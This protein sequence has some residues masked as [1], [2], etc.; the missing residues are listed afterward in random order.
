MFPESIQRNIHNFQ[1]V[2]EK[3]SVEGHILYALKANKSAVAADVSANAGIGLDASS[4]A[5]LRHGLAHG[6][7]G[8]RIGI[9]GPIK[10]ARLLSL[11]AL[12]G[13]LVTIDALSELISF[14]NLLNRLDASAQPR[15]L[16]RWRP[17]SQDTSR[18]GMPKAELDECLQLLASSPR[19]K[20][21]GFSFHLGGYSIEERA[22]GIVY[23]AA[24]LERAR[25]AGFSC[26]KLNIGGGMT[27]S[28]LEAGTWRE[29]LTKNA[30]ELFHSGRTFADF[31]PYHTDFPGHQ[32]LARLLDWPLSHGGTVA[33]MLRYKRLCLLLEPG[34][35]LLDQAGITLFR[36]R[37]MKRSNHGHGIVTV[38]GSSFSL[39][40]QW[41][42]S[43]F[44]PDP[45]L[46]KAPGNTQREPVLACVSGSTCLEQDMVS[47]RKIA[48]EATPEPGDLLVYANT[49]GYQMD[50]NESAFHHNPIPEKIA[51]FQTPRGVVWVRDNEF[52]S[53]D[54]AD[55]LHPGG[56]HV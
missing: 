33:E 36:V 51:V 47:W 10:D 19:L 28:Y 13:C 1:T 38:E 52:S 40:E 46:L 29:F 25:N 31:Y 49:A 50:S 26:T 2:L 55:G 23:L 14:K 9:T 34:R 43:E 37:G 8:S 22:Q 32:F 54:M 5:E 16:L 24:A 53:L 27:V 45:L 15:I 56:Q 12:H 30:P 17:A 18:F 21:E 7:P 48:W 3:R 42:N 6:A 4:L 35:S 39:S 44:L 20:L 11:A 41:F